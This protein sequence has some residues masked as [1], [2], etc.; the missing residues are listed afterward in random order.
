MR[1]DFEE[2]QGFA[3]DVARDEV[4]CLDLCIIAD[5]AEE[6]I[7]DT[8]GTAGAAGN[9]RRAFCVHID[10]QFCRGARDDFGKLLGRIV[11]EAIDEAEAC[12]EWCGDE[13][14]TCG[15][16]DQGEARQFEAH[17][18]C[19][20]ALIDHDIDGIIFHRGIEIFFD[21]F[22]H[23]MNLVD[24]D[25]IAGFERGEEAREV[26]GLGDDGAGRC[27]DVDTHCFAE[28]VGERGF[29]ESGRA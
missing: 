7:G 9:F 4:T 19:V 10:V 25:D 6:V 26:A 28:D 20:R 18:A 13:A 22:S 14:D 29:A 16:A 21:G 17:G 2:A 3:R 8:R 27:F 23:A 5:A 1:I 24:E 15:G 12:A 11:I